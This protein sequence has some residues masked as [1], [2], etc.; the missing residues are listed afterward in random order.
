MREEADLTLSPAVVESPPANPEPEQHKTARAPGRS[1]ASEASGDKL[2]SY[3]R[4]QD[5]QPESW[6][7][8]AVRRRGG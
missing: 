4:D 6:T 8:Q 3:G 7:P 1:A 2:P 5:W